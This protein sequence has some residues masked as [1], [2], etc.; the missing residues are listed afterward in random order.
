MNAIDDLLSGYDYGYDFGGLLTSEIRD[1]QDNQFDQDITYGYDLTNQLT[2]ALFS[3]Q[4]DEHYQYDANGNRLSVSI[5]TTTRAYAPAGPANQLD[6][7]GEFNYQYDPEGNLVLKTEIATGNVSVYEYDHRNRLIRVKERSGSTILSESEYVYDARGRRIAASVDADGEELGV[8]QTTYYVYNGE[9]TWADF[10]G[11]YAF[12]GRRGDGCVDLV[13]G[14]VIGPASPSKGH[15]LLRW[16]CRSR[17]GATLPRCYI[18]NNICF[19]QRSS[20]L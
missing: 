2:E 18:R 6:S 14:T 12:A 5:G 8:A 13:L 1:H 17:H 15:A 20:P 3:G 11:S 4:D 9:N 7:D 19:I 16:L 10:D